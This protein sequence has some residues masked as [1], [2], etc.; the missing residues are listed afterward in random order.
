MNLSI[1]N[2]DNNNESV[3]EHLV[4]FLC[5]CGTTLLSWWHSRRPQGHR[6]GQCTSEQKEA[7]SSRTLPVTLTPS[8]LLAN[9]Q[10]SLF[11]HKVKA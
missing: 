8:P 4:S 2:K 9:S 3:R 5:L 11:Q 10:Y 7:D 1:L 6:P